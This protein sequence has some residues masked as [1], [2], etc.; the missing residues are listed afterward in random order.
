M[1]GSFCAGCTFYP[2]AVE[3][4]GSFVSPHITVGVIEFNFKQLIFN[5][6][7]AGWLAGWL[8][9]F[10]V[11]LFLFCFFCVVL[12]ISKI[13]IHTTVLLLTIMTIIIII[14]ISSSSSSSSSSSNS[15]SSSK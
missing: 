5:Y 14:I 3:T 12:N 7:L 10:I 2:V 11:C 13:I 9:C 8:V 6:K 1:L 4:H 15:S